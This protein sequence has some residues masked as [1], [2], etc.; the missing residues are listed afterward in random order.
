MDV[1]TAAWEGESRMAVSFFGEA[2]RVML[3]HRMAGKI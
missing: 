1:A 2:R 3:A